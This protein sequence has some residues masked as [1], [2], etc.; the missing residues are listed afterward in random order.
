MAVDWR[1][2]VRDAAYRAVPRDQRGVIGETLY[3]TAGERGVNRNA[4]RLAAVLVDDP[5]HVL[6]RAPRRIRSGPAGELLRDRVH[7]QDTPVRADHQ[8]RIADGVQSDGQVALALARS[9]L[10]GE[11]RL[12]LALQCQGPRIDLGGDRRRAAGRGERHQRDQQRGQHRDRAQRARLPAPAGDGAEVV[13]AERHLPGPPDEVHVP[14]QDHGLPRRRWTAGDMARCRAGGP[15]ADMVA[16]AP[17]PGLARERR[18][19]N[20]HVERGHRESAQFPARFLC[21]G[22]EH[23][24]GGLPR[25]GEGAERRA[26]RFATGDGLTHRRAARGVGAV[27]E[28]DARAGTVMGSG[29]PDRKQVLMRGRRRGTGRPRHRTDADCGAALVRERRLE[30][31]AFRHCHARRPVHR[32]HSRQGR[33]ARR[34]YRELLR[35]HIAACREQSFHRTQRLDIDVQRRQAGVEGL[36]HFGQG[37]AAPIR[38]FRALEPDLG[39]R[40]QCGGCG[41]RHGDLQRARAPRNAQAGQQREHQGRR[42]QHTDDVC[43]PPVQ[44]GHRRAAWREPAEHGLCR[45][46][47]AG[48]DHAC[49]RA[50]QEQEPRCVHRRRQRH[51]GRQQPLRQLP[52]REGLQRRCACDCPRQQGFAPGQPVGRCQQPVQE[53]GCERSRPDPGPAPPAEYQQRA[54]GD[55]GRRPYGHGRATG[56]RQPTRKFRRKKISECRPHAADQGGHGGAHLTVIV[57][58]SEMTG[59]SCGMCR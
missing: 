15:V 14:R 27:I 4:R 16:D 10:G 9:G 35:G 13:A 17:A 21:H 37:V 36:L 52:S 25:R 56:D 33:H 5:E 11:P 44:P 38:D 49:D 57:I 12:Q 48:S 54:E 50:A 30:R 51:G 19:Q 32:P 31:C 46:H 58:R 55:T 18:Q 3:G 24:D 59:G 47:Q 39:A 7:A 20:L 43:E 6:H 41:E 34:E 28:A 23:Q 2:A 53:F 45:D 22:S 40:N 1:R 42:Q 8:H 26:G 29:E